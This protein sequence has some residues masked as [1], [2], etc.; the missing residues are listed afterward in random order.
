MADEESRKLG[1]SNLKLTYCIGGIL[2]F[3]LAGVMPVYV[4][5]IVLVVLLPV[6]MFL[7]I[8]GELV[9]AKDR[10]RIFPCCREV[11]T[12]EKDCDTWSPNADEG[13][14]SNEN[15]YIYFETPL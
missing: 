2:S 7:Y 14:C 11:V 15:N 1:F 4:N 8:V 12:E 6:S 10:A 13:E 3:F 9:Y 5:L